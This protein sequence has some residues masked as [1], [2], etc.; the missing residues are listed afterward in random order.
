MNVVVDG[1]MTNY[2]KSG[3]GSKTLV[4]IHGWGDTAKTFAHL[5]DKLSDRYTIL[6]VDLP[7]FGGSQKPPVAWDLNNYANFVAAW[8]SKINVKKIDMIAGHS[9]GGSVAI[10]AVA[11]QIVRA[12]K[13]VLLASAGVRG[14]KGFKKRLMWIGAQIGKLPLYVMP[15]SKA[16]RIKQAL[17]KQAGSDFLLYPEMR[18]TFKKSVAQDVRDL[19]SKIKIPTLII[20]GVKDKATPAVYGEIYHKNISNSKLE[21]IQ[22]GHMLHKHQPELVTKMIKEFD[23]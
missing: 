15:P 14:K 18:E 12:D 11:E 5:F 23:K 9:F 22:A 8:L 17:Y 19:S 20:Y 2:L 16:R 7:G 3:S 21:L 4:F 6:A 10:V 1:L 13:L